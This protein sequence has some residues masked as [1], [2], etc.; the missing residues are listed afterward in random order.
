MSLCDFRVSL[1]IPN[2]STGKVKSRKNM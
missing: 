1:T 2:G